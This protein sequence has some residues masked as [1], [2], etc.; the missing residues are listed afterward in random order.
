[1]FKCVGRYLFPIQMEAFLNQIAGVKMSSVVEIPNIESD[2]L[3]AAVI[4]K[5]ENIECT[6][7]IILKSIAGNYIFI[8]LFALMIIV[9]IMNYE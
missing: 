6:E 3:I 2:N 9:M 5:F 8:N 4:E 7:E 1:M